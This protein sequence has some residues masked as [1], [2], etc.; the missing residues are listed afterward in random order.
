MLETGSIQN[1]PQT[2]CA[3][4]QINYSR[5]CH[6][7]NLL[8]RKLYF[9]LLIS[10]VKNKYSTMMALDTFPTHTSPSIFTFGDATILMSIFDMI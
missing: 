8:Q 5:E 1:D 4:C 3:M 10:H 6:I 7:K 9:F 2:V